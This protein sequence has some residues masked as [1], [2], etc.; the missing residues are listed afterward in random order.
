MLHNDQSPADLA[1][2][3]E[4]EARL[5]RALDAIKPAHRQII[6]WRVHDEL[7]WG[8]IAAQVGRSEDAVR[9]V[10]NR[11]IKRLKQRLQQEDAYS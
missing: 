5:T 11:A 10:W 9:M 4:R 8:Q 7:S 2:V 6:L 1:L 3:A